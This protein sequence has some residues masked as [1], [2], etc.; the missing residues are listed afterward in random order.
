MINK[1]N[2]V[3]KRQITEEIEN[4]LAFPVS[5]KKKLVKHSTSLEDGLQ[6]LPD[7]KKKQKVTCLY[8]SYRM[9]ESKEVIWESDSST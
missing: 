5:E 7:F 9:P 2:E 4:L 6:G 3:S 8:K 1:K